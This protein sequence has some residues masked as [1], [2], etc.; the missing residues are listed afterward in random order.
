MF[1]IPINKILKRDT[2]KIDLKMNLK[3]NL[4]IELSTVVFFCEY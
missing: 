3:I 4:K 2:Y 1:Q